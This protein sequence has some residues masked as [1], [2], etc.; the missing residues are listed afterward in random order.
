LFSNKKN[1]VVK[2]LDLLR[3]EVRL[4]RKMTP[5]TED[6]KK[7]REGRYEIID[8]FLSFWFYFIDRLKSYIEQERFV[9]LENNF[10]ANFNSFVGRKFEKFVLSLIKDKVIFHDFAFSSVGKQWGKI[11]NT[12][13]DKNQYEIDIVALNEKTKEILF[14]EC[15]WQEKVNAEK[16]AKELSEKAKYVNWNNESRKESYAIF[17]KSF[18]KKIKEFEGKKVYCFDLKDISRLLK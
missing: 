3:R 17:A 4:V 2:Y 14:V 16:T 13:K 10:D 9:E 8:N 15:K 18:S 12:E 7:S 6:A 11:P 5:L 1:E